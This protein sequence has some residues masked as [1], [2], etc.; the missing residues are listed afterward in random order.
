MRIPSVGAFVAVGSVEGGGMT[1][2]L[3]R[4]VQVFG[5]LGVMAYGFTWF[6][7]WARPRRELH[8]EWLWRSIL[9]MFRQAR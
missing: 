3:I 6:Y 5:G 7:Y 1:Y 8:T 4:L 9:D 2:L